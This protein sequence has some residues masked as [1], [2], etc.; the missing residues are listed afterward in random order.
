MSFRYKLGFYGRLA[1]DACLIDFEKAFDSIWLDR[2]IYKLIKK[3]FPP[4]MDQPTYK[5]LQ[6]VDKTCFTYGCPIWFN[7]TASWMEKLHWKKFGT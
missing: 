6:N 5:L 7:V 4:H 3:D 2:L 1:V